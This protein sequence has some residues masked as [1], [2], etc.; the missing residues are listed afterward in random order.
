MEKVKKFFQKPEPSQKCKD[1]AK[2]DQNCLLLVKWP[3]FVQKFYRSFEWWY[4][5][6]TSEVV[7]NHYYQF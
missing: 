3:I 4:F 1:K 6:I 5:Y 7:V 2:Y